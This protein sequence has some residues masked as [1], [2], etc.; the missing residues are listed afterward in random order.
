VAREAKIA[1]NNTYRTAHF[2]AKVAR[3]SRRKA[4]L[5]YVD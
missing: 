5:S 1:E 4:V 3:S 2:N